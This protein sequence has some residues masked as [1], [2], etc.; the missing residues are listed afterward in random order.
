MP[1]DSHYIPKEFQRIPLRLP[2]SGPVLRDTARLSQRYPLLRAMGSLVSQHG[3]LGAIPPLPFSKS[4]PLG[5]HSNRRAIP[6]LKRGISAILARYPMKTRQLGAIPPSAKWY[7][8]IWGGISHW[9]AKGS[10]ELQSAPT[11]PDLPQIP[12]NQQQNKGAGRRT[13]RRILPQNPSPKK[14]QNGALLFP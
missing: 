8:A 5:E 6:T 14:G 1:C 7:C 3:Q 10:L 11:F 13:G 4:F 2:L 12:S 9:A